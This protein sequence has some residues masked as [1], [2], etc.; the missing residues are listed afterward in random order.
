MDPTR[1]LEADHRDVEELFAQIEKAEGK[2]R[3]PFVEELATSL[4]AHME[5]EEE[6]VYPKMRPVTGAE[7]VQ[8]GETEH[9]LA[10]KALVEVQRLAPDEPGFGAALDA[11]KAGIA[12]HIEEEEDDDFPDLRKDGKEVLAEMATPFMATRMELGLP[13]KADALAAA[14]PKDE[15]VEEAT[16]IGIDGA[17]DM[18][19]D[20]LAEALAAQMA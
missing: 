7:A 8:E 15:L 2:D 13:M 11:L 12:H 6:V 9:D 18:N 19:K 17:K 10:R 5:L 4:Q 16:N 20:Q 3:L 14:F 1:M